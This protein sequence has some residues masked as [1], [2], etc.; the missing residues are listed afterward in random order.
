[1]DNGIGE[2]KKLEYSPQVGFGNDGSIVVKNRAYRRAWK[3]RAM[4][5][6]KSSKKYYTT[7]RTKSRKK[8]NG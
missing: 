7:K 6:G 1:M 4:L 8:R 5:E 2:I 3:N